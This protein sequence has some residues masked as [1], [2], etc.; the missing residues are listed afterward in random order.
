MQLIQ[1][2]GLSGDQPLPATMEK[3]RTQTGARRKPE[4]AEDFRETSTAPQ[5]CAHSPEVSFLFYFSFSLGR[6]GSPSPLQATPPLSFLSSW[7]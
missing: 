6:G 3:E 2:G 5:V 4:E 1:A 7:A